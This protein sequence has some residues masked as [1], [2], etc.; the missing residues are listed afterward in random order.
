MAPPLIP[1][2]FYP[3]PIPIFMLLVLKAPMESP[4]HEKQPRTKEGAS[5]LESER[6]ELKSKLYQLEQLTYF[7]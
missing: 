7:I 2:H 3:S 1:F 4:V 6:P 5:T